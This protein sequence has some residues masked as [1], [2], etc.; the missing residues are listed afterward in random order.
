MKRISLKA[1][2][3][4]KGWTQERLEAETE[5]HGRRISQGLISKLET[6]AG[7]SP[8]YVTVEALADALGIANPRQLKFGPEDH[9]RVAS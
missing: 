4:K 9:E 1:A 8:E 7:Y 5:R 3:E 6:I 2:R